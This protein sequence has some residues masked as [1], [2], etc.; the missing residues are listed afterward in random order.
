MT[1]S[2]L[3]LPDLNILRMKTEELSK[4]NLLAEDDG[5]EGGISEDL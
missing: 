4:T 1:I 5:M 2:P 3:K